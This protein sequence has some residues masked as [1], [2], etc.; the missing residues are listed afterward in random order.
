MVEHTFLAYFSLKKVE[1]G[2][3]FDQNHGPTPLEKYQIF[4]FL[5]F[6]ILESKN[7]F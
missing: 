6:V 2:Q 7:A 5:N 3:I 1:K 4:N